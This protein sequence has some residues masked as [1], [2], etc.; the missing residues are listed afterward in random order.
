MNMLTQDSIKAAL[1]REIAEEIL[2]VAKLHVN[3]MDADSI[4]QILGSTREE[5]DELFHTQDFKDV[6]LLVG[7]EQA[8]LRTGNDSTWDGIENT[9]LEGLSKRVHLERDTDTL[10]RIAAVANKAQR[11]LSQNQAHVLDP[12]NAQTRVPLKL[13]KRFTEKINAD[14]SMER[15]AT[16]EVSVVNGTA[17]TPSFESINEIFTIRTNAPVHAVSPT[18]TPADQ[19]MTRRSVSNQ[20]ELEAFL[21][22]MPDE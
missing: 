1:N 5:V 16:Q 9:A 13:T 11:R 2:V 7:V 17:K 22:G 20:S 21:K 10:L 8:R 15:S 19:M 6:R 3:G 18:V 12:A 4:A 14:G